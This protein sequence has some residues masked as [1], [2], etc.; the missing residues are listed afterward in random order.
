MDLANG[1][2]PRVKISRKKCNDSKKTDTKKNKPKKG[3]SK[4]NEFP[5][6]PKISIFVL[7]SNFI[8]SNKTNERNVKRL[9]RVMF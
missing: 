2:D 4:K 6:S 3:E 5:G 7:C 1:N 8:S 9:V